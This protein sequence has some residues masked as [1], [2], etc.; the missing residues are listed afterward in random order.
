MSDPGDDVIT[1]S[2]PGKSFTD[3]LLLYLS[4]TSTSTT[5]H[6]CHHL[7]V[8]EIT[9]SLLHSPPLPP[10]PTSSPLPSP[11]HHLF[12]RHLC[13]NYVQRYTGGSWVRRQTGSSGEW[14]NVLSP[15]FTLLLLFLL[16]PPTPRHKLASCLAC[17]SVSS[18]VF[19]AC[20]VQSCLL[21]LLL[22][23]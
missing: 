2:L 22:L 11:L 4:F 20:P 12:P 6:S 17:V 8:F 14:R 16:L 19:H 9:E 10:S 23:K 18:L 1:H 5:F 7:N 21:V 15:T 13:S 3:I